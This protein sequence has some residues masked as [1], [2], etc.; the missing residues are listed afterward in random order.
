MLKF[1]LFVLKFSFL[2]EFELKK[3]FV[4]S[5]MFI[6]KIFIRNKN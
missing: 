6:I 4:P 3:I 5:K 2:T 1:K